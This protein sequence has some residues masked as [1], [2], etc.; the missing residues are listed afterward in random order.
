MQHIW[1][2]TH[3]NLS[4]GEM[5]THAMWEIREGIRHSPAGNTATGK[6]C[7]RLLNAHFLEVNEP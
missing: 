6:L 3:L 5:T 4:D 2:K 1:I 7:L